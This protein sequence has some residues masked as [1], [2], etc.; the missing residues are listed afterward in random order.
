[1]IPRDTT[2][3]S[4]G[5]SIDAVPYD[6]WR[7]RRGWCRD[8][9]PCSAPPAGRVE[10]RL[11]VCARQ[12]VYGRG[13]GSAANPLC[14]HHDD[15]LHESQRNLRGVARPSDVQFGPQ[16]RA[17]CR[18]G[19]KRDVGDSCGLRRRQPAPHHHQSRAEH[20]QAG[21]RMVERSRIRRIAPASPYPD[22]NIYAGTMES[23]TR[24]RGEPPR[25]S[26]PTARASRSCRTAT[27]TRRST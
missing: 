14:A 25:S 10:M 12:S 24:A 11:Y 27:A 21:R 7:G 4:A 1:M 19:P 23:P 20:R 13:A 22:L 2:G 3:A 17:C 8:P 9:E 16:S 6:R 26:H 5:R 18:H 15:E